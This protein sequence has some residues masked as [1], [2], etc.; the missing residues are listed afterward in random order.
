MATVIKLKRSETASAIP[1]T[2]DLAVGELAINTV[3]KLFYIRNTGNQIIPVANY[4]DIDPAEVDSRLDA[5]E[6]TLSSSTFPTGDYG[7]L[8]AL[9]VDAFGIPVS[10]TYDCSTTPTGAI[11][12]V[13]L[14]AF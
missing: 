8:S 12:E 5:L 6:S 9:S 13:D 10:P 4:V 2:S 14:G 1:T 3:D 11:S 7:N